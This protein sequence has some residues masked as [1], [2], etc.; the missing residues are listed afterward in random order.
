MDLLLFVLWCVLIFSFGFV[1]GIRTG[2]EA[3]N[4]LRVYCKKLQMQL[5]ERKE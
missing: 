3:R 1:C 2:T 4:R 5:K